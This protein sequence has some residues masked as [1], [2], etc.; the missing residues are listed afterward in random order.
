MI[1]P[2]FREKALGI[3][4]EK[5]SGDFI[6]R[7]ERNFATRIAWFTHKFLP[8]LKAN[9][10]SAISVAILLAVFGLSLLHESGV[11]NQFNLTYLFLI[12]L[13][14]L[15]SITITDKI[16]GSL[17]R[18]K[19]EVTQRG[20]Y[21]DRAVHF[22]YPFIFYFAVGYF[23]FVLSGELMIFMLTLFLGLLTQKQIFFGEARLMIKEKIVNRTLIPIDLRDSNVPKNNKRLPFFL[24]LIDYTTFMLYAWTLFLYIG[25]ASLSIYHYEA[26]YKLYLMHITLSLAVVSYRVFYSYPKNK[27]FSD[28]VLR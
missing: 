20:L 7:Q 17:A 3:K 4:K 9:H 8:F 12:Q 26:A 2:E 21:F 24:R 28:K 1:Y 19:E 13:C 22:L 16:D 27:L 25:L 14:L 11:L 18:V 10:V 6:Y 5:M 15:Y 23:F